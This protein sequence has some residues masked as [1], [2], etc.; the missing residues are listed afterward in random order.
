MICELL[1]DGDDNEFSKLPA[2]FVHGGLQCNMYELI[3][4]LTL[5]LL[6]S[7]D[8]RFAR[9]TSSF[10]LQLFWMVQSPHP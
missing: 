1:V 7:W 6:A 9:V 10:P 2:F 4:T 3:V 5:V 8:F